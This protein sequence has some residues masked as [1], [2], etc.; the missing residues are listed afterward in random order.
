MVASEE[1]GVAAG[2]VSARTEGVVPCQVMHFPQAPLSPEHM[3]VVEG[4]PDTSVDGSL[5]L[6][7]VASEETGV[8]AGTVSA[9]T[10][11]VVPRQVMH[12][13]Q[14]PLP[15][16]HMAVVEGQ[17][18]TS[19]D[20][21]LPLKMVASEETGVAAIP[22]AARYPLQ[23]EPLVPRFDA[24]DAVHEGY[25]LYSLICLSDPS[26]LESLNAAGITKIVQYL[27]GAYKAADF[28]KDSVLR[29]LVKQM[30]GPDPTVGQ[31]LAMCCDS[32]AGRML[33]TIAH[34]CDYL[35]LMVAEVLGLHK[36]KILAMIEED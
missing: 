34:S 6:E 8:A 10:E 4:Q 3:A 13:P 16:E 36:S 33:R 26:V 29:N 18:D 22:A 15:P 35:G 23:F 11:G 21:S 31:C 5:P 14:A 20:G 30:A 19:I 7:M 25:N 12:F 28:K 27:R 9:R 1:T 17:F 24:P 32:S 2:T